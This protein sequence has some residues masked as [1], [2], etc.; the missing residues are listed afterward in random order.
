MLVGVAQ[1][2]D[3]E[4]VAKYSGDWM[5]HCHL[6]HHM[7]N[8]M[9]SMVGPMMMSHGN[10]AQTGKSMEAGMGV[11]RQGNALSEEMGPAMGR[12]MG[13]TTTD[14]SVSNLVAQAAA[15]SNEFYVCPMHPEV[16]SDKPGN[17]SKCNMVLVKKPKPVAANTEIYACPMH[18]EVTST[19]PGNCSKCSMAL[20]KK[21]SA[22]ALSEADRKKVP[23]Y[24]QDMMMAMDE[25]V[26]KPETWGLASG[27]TASMM[28]M[29]TLVRVLPEE[30]YNEVMA[31]VKA[32]KTEK[33]KSAPEHKHGE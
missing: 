28:G 12:G 7:M 1:A 6:P 13:M 8:Q 11:V 33:P 27:W 10:G 19:K 26:A 32:G 30:K 20:V 31:R 14:K 16:T 29:M 24:P 18:P 17:C 9:V 4:F 22:M 23:G 3:V 21:Q 25:D 2:R 15:T 5:L